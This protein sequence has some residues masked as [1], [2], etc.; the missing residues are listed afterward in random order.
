MQSLVSRVP[1]S[2]CSLSLGYGEISWRKSFSPLQMYNALRH[3]AKP[4][5]HHASLAPII[6]NWRAGAHRAL[7]P[8]LAAGIA[9]AAHCFREM[10]SVLQF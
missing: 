2:S 7:C 6:T 10:L 8:S 1:V 5:H 9:A 4:A 3:S